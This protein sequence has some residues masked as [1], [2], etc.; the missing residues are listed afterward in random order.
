MTSVEEVVLA[1]GTIV[2]DAGHVTLPAG[3]CALDLAAAKAGRA[4]AIPSGT[5]LPASFKLLNG[6]LAEKSDRKYTLLT[7]PEGY[8]GP[9]PAVTGLPAPWIISVSGRAVRMVWPS[10]TVIIR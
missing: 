5:T 4:T 7:L 6:N 9:I 10:F 3:Q 1:G 2:N 8:S